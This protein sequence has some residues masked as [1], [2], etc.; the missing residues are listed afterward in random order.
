M[1]KRIA[2]C[3]DGTWNEEGQSDGDVETRTNVRFLHN[4]LAKDDTQVGHYLPGVGTQTLQKVR[5][6][7]FGW[8]LFEQIKDGYQAL[9]QSYEPGDAIYLFGFSRGAYS[10][11]SLGGMILHCGVLKREHLDTKLDVPASVLEVLAIKQD[12]R[13]LK[14]PHSVDQAFA[15]YKHA[16]AGDRQRQETQAFKA[17]YCHDTGI[18]MIG[19]WDTVGALGLPDKLVLP[20]LRSLDNRARNELFGFLDTSLNGRVESAYHALAIDE[21]REPFLPT[22]WTDEPTGEARVNRPGTNVEQVWFAGAHSNVG[23][24]YRDPGLSDVALDWMIRRAQRQA[25]VFQPQELANSHADATGVRRDS[26]AEFMQVGAKQQTKRTLLGM[27]SGAA[28]LGL[29]RI[30]D[31][32]VKTHRTIADG[33]WVHES[34][35]Q[36][37]R[38]RLAADPLDASGYRPASLTL[39]G[40]AGS[41]Q[42]DPA[43]YHV[44]NT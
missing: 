5:G 38:A 40:N 31:V 28:G 27:L 30:K 25:L 13:P 42:V 34:V 8:G 1:P 14:P 36:R 2:I 22:L 18:R 20:V 39:V 12:D 43:K 21:H 11:R 23:G 35:N 16:Y 10:A 41:T 19:V 7:T 17:R 29:D 3:L 4:A 37:L 15:M 26:L 44:V 33:S 32:L 24:G 6:G 9:A